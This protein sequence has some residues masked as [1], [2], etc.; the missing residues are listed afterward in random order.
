MKFQLSKTMAIIL[1]LLIATATSPKISYCKTE[2]PWNCYF[3]NITLM[4]A[5]NGLNQTSIC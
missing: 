4:Q 1:L 5:A 3:W 2:A